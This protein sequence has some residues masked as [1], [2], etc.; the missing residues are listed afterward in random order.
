M[1]IGLSP[2]SPMCFGR[3]FHGAGYQEY[4][5]IPGVRYRQTLV[6][7]AMGDLNMCDVAT[8]THV[9]ALRSEGVMREDAT[10]ICGEPLP[11]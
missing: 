7:G 10:F 4:G 9:H 3:G 8:A 11:L 6:V 1:F 2:V 5:G